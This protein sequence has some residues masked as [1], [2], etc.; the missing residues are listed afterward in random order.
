[1]CLRESPYASCFLGGLDAMA[2]ELM[3]PTYWLLS[4][5]LALQ[6]TTAEKREHRSQSCPPAHALEVLAKGPLLL[7]FL[8]LSVPFSLLGLLLWLP[9][10]GARRP[11]AYQHTPSQASPEE[12]VLPGQG[13][14]FHFVSANICLLPD[15]LAKFSNLA[16]TQ[17]RARHIA[18][19]LVQA[20]RH[21]IPPH[22]GHA[23]SGTGNVSKGK[24]YGTADS[25]TPRVCPGA[26]AAYS[27]VAAEGPLLEGKAALPREITASFPSDVD[28]L[29][30]QEVF[31]QE[32]AKQLLRLLGPCF[33]HILYDVGT[34]GLQGCSALKLLNSGLFLASR[35]PL[36][37]VQYHCY[38]NGSGEDAFS[39]KGLLCVQVKG[40][41][42]GRVGG[43]VGRDSPGLPCPELDPSSG[44]V[45]VVSL[46]WQGAFVSP[47]PSGGCQGSVMGGPFAQPPLS[48]G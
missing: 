35:Y 19:A 15:G 5:L 17:W 4:Q 41:T 1:M 32:A 24:K 40:G 12:W 22:E 3:Y 42:G 30:L 7:L 46:N 36:L 29:C 27:D 13:K 28:F 38:P 25:R 20:A 9:L 8:L 18:Q 10:Q 6:W 23:R 48:S 44:K 14:A 39:A 47:F 37:A 16:R 43:W 26:L 21:A 11:F 34:Y 33:Q 45:S 2:R 31:D